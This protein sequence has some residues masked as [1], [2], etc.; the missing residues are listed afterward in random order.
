MCEL[1]EGDLDEDAGVRRMPHVDQRRAQRLDRPYERRRPELL[2]L[3]RH[4]VD[5]VLGELH[6]LGSHQREEP[7]AEVADQL[8]GERAGIAAE[9][10]R[11][12]HGGEHAPRI[13]VDHRLDELVEV[14]HVGD[15]AARGRHQL[16]RRQRVAG[17]T[18]ALREDGVDGGV[19]Q[20]EPGVGGDPPDVL[21][22][23]V[24]G[25]EMELQVLGAAP[26]RVADPLR[27]GGGEHEHDVRRR[28]LERLQQRCLGGPR[29]HV[30]LVEDVDAMAPRRAER[31]LLDEVTDRVDPAVA[32][33]V[34]L[35]DVVADAALD[36]Q[37]R[38]ALAAR[39][40]VDRSFAV[41]HLGEDARRRGLARAT[42]SGEQVRLAFTT[43]RDGVAEGAH[44]MVLPLELAE[45]TWPVAAIQ[46]LGGHRG[47]AYPG[48]VSAAGPRPWTRPGRR[49]QNRG[50]APGYRGR[51]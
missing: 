36:G 31:R 16:E 24:G 1:H 33:G 19:G 37:A 25:Q 9:A 26:D 2:R 32:G 7:V 34:E 11:V 13:V 4:L 5:A 28:F 21:G 39:F 46:R 3:G 8:L 18:A 30:D 45:A 51:R 48:G 6:Q 29:E 12:G 35:V 17:R 42:R 50:P 44:D 40:A 20:L 15:V 10:D 14:D 47:R 38:L 43:A 22:E 41:E 23:R 49:W 27:V